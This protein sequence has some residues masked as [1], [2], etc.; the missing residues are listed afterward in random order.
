VVTA[1]HEGQ[2]AGAPPPPD[3]IT[4]GVE[5]LT[6]RGAVGQHA[7]ADVRQREVFEVALEGGGVRLDR[8]RGETEVARA[9]VSALA[10]VDAALEGDAV[11]DDAGLVEARIACDEPR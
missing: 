11:D 4:R 7:V 9:G 2:E 10:E 3:L 8:V 5:L 6:G 1:E